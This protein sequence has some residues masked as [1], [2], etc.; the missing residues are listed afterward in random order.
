MVNFPVSG[1]ISEAS[2]SEAR[3]VTIGGL[4]SACPKRSRGKP[5]AANVK[6]N[7][8]NNCLVRMKIRKRQL[9]G[10]FAFTLAAFGLPRDLFGQAETSPP[11]VTVLASDPDASEIGPDTGKFTITRTGPTNS[12]LLVF[13]HAGGS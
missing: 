12:D 4:V 13:Y 6:A 10:L 1:P 11:I 5:K 7:R 9:L 2:G 8:P 3:T